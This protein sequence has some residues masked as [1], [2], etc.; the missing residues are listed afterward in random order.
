[1][2]SQCPSHLSRSCGKTKSLSVSSNSRRKQ[3]LA[4]KLRREEVEKQNAALLLLA[5]KKQRHEMEELIEKNR[6]KLVEAKINE[7]ELEDEGSP[8]SAGGSEVVEVLRTNNDN[9]EEQVRNWVN[10]SST[11]NQKPSFSGSIQLPTEQLATSISNEN[12]SGFQNRSSATVDVDHPPAG[13]STTLFLLNNTNANDST[14]VRSASETLVVADHH[15]SGLNDNA[16][17]SGFSNAAIV[18]VNSSVP[19]MPNLKPLSARPIVTFRVSL[20]SQI[21]N[22]VVS[23][24]VATHLV[25]SSSLTAPVVTTITV[26]T[27]SGSNATSVPSM[28]SGGTVYCYNPASFP[29]AISPAAKHQCLQPFNLRS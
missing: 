3:F 26:T 29:A 23:T 21:S 8:A 27:P 5:E 1:M 15:V 13:N 14:D 17:P 2:S 24:E 16:P 10:N 9:D 22:N 18:S 25:E 28:Y 7:M 4:A 6:Q 12:F 19:A 11:E 20:E